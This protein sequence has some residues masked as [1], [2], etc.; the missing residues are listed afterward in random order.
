[1][2]ERP[3][4]QNEIAQAYDDKF[5]MLEAARIEYFSAIASLLDGIRDKLHEIR[6]NASLPDGI[7]LETERRDGAGFAQQTLECR[8]KVGDQPSRI[9][10]LCRLSTPWTGV[11]GFLQLGVGASLDDRLIASS[12][13][14]LRRESKEDG[15]WGD[16]E[17]HPR[18]YGAVKGDS[19]W[20]Y[21]T[22]LPL[23]DP[24]ILGAAAER[25]RQLL[26][27]ASEL[28]SRIDDEIQ[29][30]TRMS[31]VLERVRMEWRPS[32]AGLGFEMRNTLGWWQGMQYAQIECKD[33]PS[34]WVGFHVEKQSLMYGYNRKG[35]SCLG[36]AEGFASSVGCRR[37]LIHGGEPGGIL[38]DKE[39][40]ER[41][42]E[43][44]LVSTLKA[45]FTQ[46][47]MT[48]KNCVLA[49]PITR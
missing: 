49:S 32:E 14:S 37:Q 9:Q 10:I 15:F 19:S 31:A 12:C 20:I 41:T 27:P 38:L 46:F 23:T 47:E 28:A 7:A 17:P 18:P 6:A 34:Y 26:P 11:P 35:E 36:L 42:S 25:I 33:Q 29:L 48:L 43:D 44:D 24:E 22:C 40:I 3:W 1:M 39:E 2:D 45:T 30:A 4:S 21:D 13:E 5:Q 8:L 16:G